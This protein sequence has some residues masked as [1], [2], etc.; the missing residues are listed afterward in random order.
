MGFDSY[1]AYL[2]SDL[3]KKI[4]SAQLAEHPNC[5]GCRRPANQV[6]HGKYTYCNL[7]GINRL[8]L[9]SSCGGC[10]FRSEFTAD[11]RKRTLSR[12]NKAFKRRRFQTIKADARMLKNYT[13]DNV[14]E[15][16]KRR[17]ERD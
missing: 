15:Q 8:H 2:A 11:G 17:L 16:F 12:A 13:P 7:S 3:W 5:F 10:H 1:K 9:I 14:D 4:R 6:H